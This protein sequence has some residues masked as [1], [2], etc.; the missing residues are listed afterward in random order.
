MNFSEEVKTTLWEIIDEMANNISNYT[1]HPEKDFSRK[2][3]WNFATLVKFIIS[4]ESQSLKNELH[5]YFGYTTDCPSNASFNQRRTPVN[6]Y[7]F[8]YL[9]NTFTKLYQTLSDKLFK[10]Y[11]I[12][13][14]DGSDI[15]ITHNPTDSETYFKFGKSKG[16]NQL[17]L[18]A[19]YD[20][21]NK[22][23]TDIVIQPGREENEHK[24]F[25]DMVNRYDGNN[26]TIFITDRGY[27]SYNNIAHVIEK[28]TYFLFRC[29]DISSN[30][31]IA[32]SKDK[33]PTTDIFDYHLALILTK[34]WPNEILNNR[35]IYRHFHNA[36]SFDFLDLDAH[37]FYNMSLRVVRFPISDNVYECIVTN[38]PDNEFTTAE[39]KEL[40]ALRWGI[41][42]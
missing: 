6:S 31:I 27:E 20:L 15:N 17:H 5:K 11:R 38:L 9:F 13:A 26:K 18:N 25:C 8:E 14:C 19:M 33:L 23:Y 24:A 42:T 41:E 32:G 39:I 16:F 37:I 4:M 29:K 35:D 12:I 7:A 22:T 36:H 34:K 3:K 28:G 1:V 30:G 40:Y 21:L 10:G 2:K